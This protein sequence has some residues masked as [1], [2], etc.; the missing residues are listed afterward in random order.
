MATRI[1]RPARQLAGLVTTADMPQP[2][3]R[4]R[5]TAAA[6]EVSRARKKKTDTRG[7]DTSGPA[8]VPP[9]PQQPQHVA[10]TRVPSAALSS[11]SGMVDIGGMPLCPADVKAKVMATMTHEEKTTTRWTFPFKD[12]ELFEKAEFTQLSCYGPPASKAR[13][14][15]CSKLG[16]GSFSCVY[17]SWDTVKNDFVAM[18]FTLSRCAAARCFRPLLSSARS[19]AAFQHP[20]ACPHVLTHSTRP[21]CEAARRAGPALTYPYAHACND[22]RACPRAALTAVSFSSQRW[23]GGVQRSEQAEHGWAGVQPGR[24]HGRK[25]TSIHPTTS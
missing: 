21:G 13:Y 17:K 14:V 9:Q 20:A 4:R 10:P 3:K 7:L 1:G 11:S 15:L 22:S 19:P 23:E 24:G 18:K 12:G 2:R 8:A 25:Q 5:S 16:E 6:A